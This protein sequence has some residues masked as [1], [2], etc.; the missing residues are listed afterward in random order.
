MKDLGHESGASKFLNEVFDSMVNC[1]TQL[2]CRK[3][4]TERA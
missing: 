3:S 4:F 1:N 2:I